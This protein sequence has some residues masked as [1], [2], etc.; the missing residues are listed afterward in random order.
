M[1]GL[2]SISSVRPAIRETKGSIVT[3]ILGFVDDNG[4]YGPIVSKDP[5]AKGKP[6]YIVV[7]EDGCRFNLTVGAINYYCNPKLQDGSDNPDY[8]G[9]AIYPGLRYEMR[10][11][12]EN[13]G[14]P[15]I[16][17]LGDDED[18]E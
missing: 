16:K 2:M 6:Y 8:V 11:D 17:F 14:R 3:D 7:F 12:T 1:S 4:N 5:K 18:D 10:R 13:D 15:I 9:D